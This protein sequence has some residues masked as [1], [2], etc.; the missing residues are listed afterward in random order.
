MQCVRPKEARR[1]RV[2]WAMRPKPRKPAVRCVGA[3]RLV[4]GVLSWGPVKENGAKLKL[5]HWVFGCPPASG[6]PSQDL[7]ITGGTVWQNL[8]CGEIGLTFPSLTRVI[9]TPALRPA[10]RASITDV[11]AALGSQLVLKCGGYY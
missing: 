6:S 5:G 3:R 1:F 11:S 2:A 9:P 7:I 8:C 10:I 4:V